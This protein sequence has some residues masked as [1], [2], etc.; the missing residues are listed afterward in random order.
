MLIMCKQLNGPV[1]KLLK[2]KQ[3][4]PKSGKKNWPG[5]AGPGPKFCNSFRAEPG[6]A[7]T[8][9]ST[10]LSAG[11]GPG[12]NFYLY[13]V[14]G[15][16]CSHTGRSRHGPEKSSPCRPLVGVHVSIRTR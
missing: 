14:V 15:R 9:I 1:L 12:L 11:T 16:D 8:E 4:G 2:T 10:F 5:R 13:F 6:R 3:S 7:R